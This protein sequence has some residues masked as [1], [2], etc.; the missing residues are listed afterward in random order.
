MGGGDRKE[1][2]GARE[3]AVWL[4]QVSESATRWRLFHAIVSLHAGQQAKPSAGVTDD[5]LGA[6]GSW[7]HDV[8]RGT[9]QRRRVSA[10]LRCS[11]GG[12][13]DTRRLATLDG[14]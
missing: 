1:E 3:E 12:A 14:I 6:A 2:L 8:S 10:G 7:S 5:G 4:V 13:G 11:E 9:G